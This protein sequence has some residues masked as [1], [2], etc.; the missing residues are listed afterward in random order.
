ML[1]F[2]NADEKTS[3]TIIGAGCKMTGNINT[4]HNVQIHGHVVGDIVAETVVIGR[5][6]L[7]EGKINAE[8]LFLHGT[9]TGPAT[10]DTANVFSH[11]RM[12]GVLTY[13]TLNITGNTGLECKL[14]KR[15]DT[16][17]K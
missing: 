16:K 2:T 12:T 5:G 9:L 13:R 8:T 17:D 3:P 6:G 15:K 10:V 1:A 11:A 14:A 4:D 7:V